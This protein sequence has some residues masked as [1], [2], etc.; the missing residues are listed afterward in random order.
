MF[1]VTKRQIHI[2]EPSDRCRDGFNVACENVGRESNTRQAGSRLSSQI[3][4]DL[5]LSHFFPDVFPPSERGEATELV[6]E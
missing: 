6:S 4:P 2:E 3:V 1:I 5:P